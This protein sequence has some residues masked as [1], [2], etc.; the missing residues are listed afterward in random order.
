M[1]YPVANGT[2]FSGGKRNEDG[3]VI[4]TGLR[5]GGALIGGPGEG[6][7]TGPPAAYGFVT[8]DVSETIESI[9]SRSAGCLPLRFGGGD[10]PRSALRRF[11]DPGDNGAPAA[12]DSA[13]SMFVIVTG[14]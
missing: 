4:G 5:P 12:L 7:P 11:P 1:K 8:N 10:S 13:D 2:K 6:V 14:G 3:C 9:G